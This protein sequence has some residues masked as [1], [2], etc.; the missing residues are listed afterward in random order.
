MRRRGSRLKRREA[1][2]ILN[3]LI[4][5]LDS[6][7]TDSYNPATPSKWQDT[8]GGIEATIIADPLYNDAEKAISFDQPSEYI[9]LGT[10]LVIPSGD[11]TM[12]LYL[13][14]LQ[15]NSNSGFFRVGNTGDTYIINNL[16]RPQIR[17]T[18]TD[19]LNPIDG[20]SLNDD[21][22]KS[23]YVSCIFKNYIDAQ[24][25][26]TIEFN[27]NG[28]T[29]HFAEHSKLNIGFSLNDLNFQWSID[30]NHKQ[31]SKA[32]HFYNKALANEEILNNLQAM[33]YIH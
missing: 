10:S 28:V 25:P 31:H 6:V 29:K 26:G 9:H 13:K 5:N 1:Y 22:G 21:I 14:P 8:I 12:S 15:I 32:W 3:G 24:N 17:I 4:F 23:V 19:I 33:Q 16:T 11:F 18:G 30:Q 2:I 20:Y 7:D 27:V